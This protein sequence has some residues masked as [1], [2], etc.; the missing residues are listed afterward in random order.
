MFNLPAVRLVSL[1]KFLLAACMLAAMVACGGGGAKSPDGATGGGGTGTGGTTST[2]TV[3]LAGSTNRVSADSPSTLTATVKTSSGATVPNTVVTFKTAGTGFAVFFPTGGT[4]LTGANGVATITLQ[5]GT[6]VGADSVSATANV[7]GTDVNSTAFG[8]EVS[9]TTVTGTPASIA[10]VDAAPSVIAIRGTGGQEISTV[11]FEIKDTNGQPIA[12]QNVSFVLSTNP[13]GAELSTASSISAANGRVS[14]TVRAGTVPAPVRVKAILA[15][16]PLVNAVSSQL[17]VSTTIPH[18]NGFSIATQTFNIEGYDV[19]GI[20]T[21]I[22][23]TLADRYGNLVPDGTAVS[24][25]IEGGVSSINPSCVTTSGKCVVL[26]SSSGLRPTDGRLT[27]L[28][29]AVGEESFTD[30]NGNGIF[31]ASEPFSDLSEAF[32]DGNENGLRDGLEEFVDFNNDGLYNVPDSFFNGILRASPSTASTTLSVRSSVVQVLS[33]S[34]AF[35]NLDLAMLNPTNPPVVPNQL[36]PIAVTCSSGS[37]VTRVIRVT[38]A[39]GQVMPAGTTI[40]FATSA[41]KITSIPTSFIVPNTN[42]KLIQTYS[43]SLQ[44]A[45]ALPTCPAPANGS[46]TF[47]VTVKTPGGLTTIQPIAVSD[48]P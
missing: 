27:V 19:D 4:A 14:T 17:V 46:G 41:G 47:T 20:S 3:T 35:F 21:N 12:G 40:N 39:R 43:V 18:Q 32:I 31:D 7:G 24:F 38:D 15:S 48:A 6:N 22:T 45:S 28:A 11:T 5:A 9:T 29:T 13:G 44:S 37:A 25:R 23:A 8:F 34:S 42:S 33:G 26:F 16:N 10:F 2:G 30:V 1:F 36:N